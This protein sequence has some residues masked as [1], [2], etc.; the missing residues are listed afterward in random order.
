METVEGQRAITGIENARKYANAHRKYIKLMFGG[1]AKRINA[2]GKSGRYLEAGAGPG[3]LAAMIAES[4]PGV[5]ITAMDLSPDMAVVAGEYIS[6][7]RLE[8]RINYIVGD[9]ADEELIKGLGT[10]DV[11]YSTFS[12][13]HWQEPERS[14]RNLLKITC[15]DGLL[16]IQDFRRM[17]WL[18]LLPLKT[19]ETD[20]IKAAL[21]ARKIGTILQNTG[22]T[23][24]SVKTS[25]PFFFQT[26]IARKQT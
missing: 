10:F 3:F 23:D 2:F 24:Y 26:V 1:L 22:I 12:M 7:R 6:E 15:E 5:S 17:N 8:D 21:S 9:V 13:H 11:V 18:R 16:F 4:N 25:F 19:G 14:I 20:S